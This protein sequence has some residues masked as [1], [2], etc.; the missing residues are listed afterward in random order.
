MK[1]NQ[2]PQLL[3]SPITTDV[4]LRPPGSEPVTVTRSLAPLLSEFRDHL[5]LNAAR[6]QDLAQEAQECKDLGA[7][8]KLRAKLCD[9]ATNVLRLAGGGRDEPEARPHVIRS[10]SDIPRWDVLSEDL[11]NKL[12][13]LFEQMDKEWE[14]AGEWPPN[15]RR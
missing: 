6:L 14:E 5:V 12:E 9:L 7:E 8:S 3:P 15:S 2:T 10:Q 11:R 4:E 1:K 13:P